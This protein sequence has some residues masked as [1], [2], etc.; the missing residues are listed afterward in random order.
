M[1]KKILLFALFFVGC[2]TNENLE[3]TEYRC[4][5]QE[6][7]ALR[8]FIVDC[9]K[10][11]N[12]LSDEEGEDLVSQCENTAFSTCSKFVAVKVQG[13]GCRDVMRCNHTIEIPLENK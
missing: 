13:F 10:A 2:E 9:A 11:A 4:S 5:S 7:P 3:W 1:L 8:A 12:P 6:M